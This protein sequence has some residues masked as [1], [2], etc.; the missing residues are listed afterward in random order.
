M[1]APE[2]REREE[3]PVERVRVR[4]HR[5]NPHEGRDAGQDLV[6]RQQEPSLLAVEA[7]VLR[8]MPEAGD[9]LPLESV[10]GDPVPVGHPAK[11]ARDRGH[12]L[13]VLRAAVLELEDVLGLEAAPPVEVHRRVL[14]RLGR[15]DGEEPAHQP[16]LVGDPEIRS[17]LLRQPARVAEVV[18]MEVGDDDPLDRAA[19]RQRVDDP[20]PVGLYL[21]ASDAGVHYRPS[22]A[23]AQQPQVDVVEREGERHPYP[24][25]A[26]RDL[27][28]R[29]GVPD[30]LERMMHRGRGH[31]YDSPPLALCLLE[32]SYRTDP[33][34][35]TGHPAPP[36]AGRGSLAP[37]AAKRA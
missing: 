9:D 26:V 8:G 19:A 37:R 14:R 6:A 35:R 2:L 32:R 29:T 33:R 5:V 20:P 15:V 31:G 7:G 13:V 11:A 10:D 4:L 23:V 25:H 18:G 21:G 28:H 1:Q 22:A 24:R 17:V 34:G 27:A 36:G 3:K 12:H 30:R 16:L